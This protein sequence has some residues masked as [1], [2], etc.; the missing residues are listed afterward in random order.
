MSVDTPG[1]VT[2]LY[3]GMV[4]ADVSSNKRALAVVRQDKDVRVI[5]KTEAAKLLSS[6][7]FINAVATVHGTTP[8]KCARIT[9]ILAISS[10]LMARMVCGRPRQSAS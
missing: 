6:D 1:N 10:C 8:K 4:T 2:M 7:E 9:P 5:D 3:S